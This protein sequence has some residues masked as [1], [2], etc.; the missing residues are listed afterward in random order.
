LETS[1][2]N[3]IFS[4]AWLGEFKLANRVVMAPMTRDRA[5]P[6]D[7][8]TPLMAEYYRQRASAGLIVTEGTQPS[9]VGK[10]YWRTPGI[11]SEAQVE[12]WRKVADA[13]HGAGGRIVMPGI[14]AIARPRTKRPAALIEAGETSAV[15]G[16]SAQFLSGASGKATAL[17]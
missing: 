6:G 9:P 8:P 12:G 13:V 4:S 1:R 7:V 17:S 5:G 16:N 10:G 11:H 14:P 3:D 15:S 2:V